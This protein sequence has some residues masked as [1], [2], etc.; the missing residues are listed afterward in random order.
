MNKPRGGGRGGGGFGNN[1]KKPAGGGGRKPPSNK[2]DIICY[3]CD[4]KGHKV[5]QCPERKEAQANAAT[6]YGGRGDESTMA[7]IAAS[8]EHS[9]CCGKKQAKGA[10]AWVVDSGCTSHMVSSDEGLTDVRWGKGRVIVAGG[11]TLDS[12]GVGRIKATIKTHQGISKLVTF[13]EVL[14]VPGLGRNLLSVKK[15]VTRRW[16]GYLYS[17][18]SRDRD[19]Q[20]R[21][22]AFASG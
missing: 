12:V 1:H 2:E 6:T 18:P 8:G 10:L 20:R 7:L 15:V 11:E 4:R 13:E 16:Q 19:E 3:R 21:A 14:L 5:W 22:H 17:V 9:N